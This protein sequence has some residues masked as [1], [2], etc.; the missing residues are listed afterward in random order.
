MTQPKPVRSSARASWEMVIDEMTKRNQVGIERY[1]VPLQPFNGR[2][3]LQDAFEEALDLTVYLAT[4]RYELT[5]MKNALLT[6]IDIEEEGSVHAMANI[7]K[8]CL[9]GESF[10]L[11]DVTVYLQEEPDY[12]I[13]SMQGI[14]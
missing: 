1:G 9:R 2:D 10:S 14:L 3:S 12:P 5:N 6:I 7:A 11:P 8:A 13:D 4:A